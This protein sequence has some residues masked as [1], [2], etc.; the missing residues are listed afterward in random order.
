MCR[1]LPRCG[2]LVLGCHCAV[3]AGD[4]V[5][6]VGYGRVSTREQYLDRQE[7]A[8]TAAGCTRC[9]FGKA[10]GRNAGRQGI[11]DAFGYM[12]PG[13]VLTV[14]SLDRLV[15]AGQGSGAQP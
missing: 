12:R 14:V 6:L 13:D 15:G 5:A 4:R 10:S 7:A 11:A 3:R 2:S 9:F 1:D 8:L